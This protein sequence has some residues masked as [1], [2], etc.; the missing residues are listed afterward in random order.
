MADTGR[1]A[2]LLEAQMADTGGAIDDFSATIGKQ[3]YSRCW[4][5]GS[6]EARFRPSEGAAVTTW[7]RVSDGGPG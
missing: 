2:A 4:A 5:H 3:V 7:T 6:A 1:R